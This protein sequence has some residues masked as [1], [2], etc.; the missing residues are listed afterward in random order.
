MKI[1]KN[2]FV[3]TF[4]N[5][6]IVM[7]AFTAIVIVLL[8]CVPKILEN[9]QIRKEMKSFVIPDKYADIINEEI[10][11]TDLKSLLKTGHAVYA[12]EVEKV[13]NNTTFDFDYKEYNGDGYY[14]KEAGV[15]DGYGYEVYTN[16]KKEELLGTAYGYMGSAFN[17][18]LNYAIIIS[19]YSIIIF[20]G[21]L[22]EIINLIKYIIKRNKSKS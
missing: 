10:L 18:A 3:K 1:F 15:A 13:K 14:I 5:T 9:N 16:S 17:K 8:M 6:I 7:L 2:S 21:V 12:K 19:V 22:S 20:I 11:E 4:V